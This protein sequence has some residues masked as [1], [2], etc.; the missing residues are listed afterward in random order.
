MSRRRTLKTVTG[1]SGGLDVYDAAVD[2]TRS[3]LAS[4]IEIAKIAENN[5]IDA[6]F[7]ADLLSF[8]AQGAIGAQE[9]LIYLC[10]VPAPELPDYVLLCTTKSLADFGSTSSR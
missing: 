4:S 6:L 9:P 7:A 1:V 8:G 2:P 5:K 10:S 3:T